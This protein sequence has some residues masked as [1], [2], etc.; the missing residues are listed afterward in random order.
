MIK[1]ILSV[2]LVFYSVFLLV[3]QPAIAFTSLVPSDAKG[4]PRWDQISFNNLGPV[5]SGTTGILTDLRVM[6]LI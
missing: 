5:M 4:L 1:R 2:F 6:Q 3:A